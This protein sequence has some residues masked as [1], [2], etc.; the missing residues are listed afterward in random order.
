MIQVSKHLT[1]WLERLPI[2]ASM[3]LLGSIARRS[4]LEL[5][6]KQIGEDERKKEAEKRIRVA[7]ETIDK[8][9][10]EAQ[11][12]LSHQRRFGFIEILACKPLG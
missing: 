1:G 5:L 12:R 9:F 8:H 2:S 11:V 7:I 4:V 10:K 6:A 3:M